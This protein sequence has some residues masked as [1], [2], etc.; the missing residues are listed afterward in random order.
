MLFKNSLRVEQ[1]E[2]IVTDSFQYMQIICNTSTK[3][4]RIIVIYDHQTAV[5]PT[6]ALISLVYW[7]V[8][9]LLEVSC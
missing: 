9:Q 2:A 8:C 5:L 7:S 4:F 1:E 6:Y 3:S